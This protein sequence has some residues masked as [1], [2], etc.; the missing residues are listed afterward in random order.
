MMIKRY[1]LQRQMEKE[2][3][4][5]N[6][7]DGYKDRTIDIWVDSYMGRSGKWVDRVDGQTGECVKGYMGRSVNR[8]MGRW[9]DE[10]MNRWADRQSR[11]CLYE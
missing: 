11:I 2:K 5:R 10:Q 8:Q 4:R 1:L 7:L 3:V 6:W 9:I